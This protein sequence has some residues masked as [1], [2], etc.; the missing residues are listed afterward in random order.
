MLPSGGCASRQVALFALIMAS[1]GRT[2][3]STTLRFS[4]T[5][6]RGEAGEL[7]LG[8]LKLYDAAGVDLQ[9]TSYSAPQYSPATGP[10]NLFDGTSGTQWRDDTFAASVGMVGSSTLTVTVPGVPAAYE[11]VTYFKQMKRDPLVWTV[12][13]QNACGGFSQV[14]SEDVGILDPG[15]SASYTPGSA[16]TID[17]ASIPN[18]CEPS[19]PSPP[20]TPSGDLYQFVFTGVR[21]PNVDGIQLGEIELFDAEGSKLHVLEATTTAPDAAI[22][23][24]NQLGDKLIDGL[25]GDGTGKWIDYGSVSYTHLTLPTILL[26]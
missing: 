10:G 19:P 13:V 20:S 26:V 1:S 16:F 7:A 12:S 4:F 25:V 14:S 11:F 9:P 8:Q 22:V 24:N 15:R 3:T 6:I 5:R 21:G 17:V 2:Q 18:A 23:N